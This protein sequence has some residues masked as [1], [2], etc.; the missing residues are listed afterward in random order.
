MTVLYERYWG[1]CFNCGA[2]NRKTNVQCVRC[3]GVPPSDG[4]SVYPER[5]QRSVRPP[6]LLV[7]NLPP[8]MSNRQQPSYREPSYGPS[9]HRP[10]P[11]RSQR[12]GPFPNSMF[13][14]SRPASASGLGPT[15]VNCPQCGI[16]NAAVNLECFNCHALRAD[17]KKYV[18]HWCKTETLS[19][20]GLQA[21]C[22]N[23]SCRH[24][25]ARGE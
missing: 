21:R 3:K 17:T 20:D 23:Q 9:Y 16:K 7:P 8:P 19:R 10:S 1:R 13:P 4:Q 15:Y 18:C 6:A 12:A 22:K 14:P 5:S 24:P 11:Y 25:V 2:I